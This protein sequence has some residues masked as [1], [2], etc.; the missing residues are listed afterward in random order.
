MSII[1]AK[2][3]KTQW[4]LREIMTQDY[5]SLKNS[6]KIWEKY[7]ISHTTVLKRSKS[8][9]LENR[10]SAPHKPARKHDFRKLVLLHFLYKKENNTLDEIEDIL[11]EQW[12]KMPRSTIWYYLITWW[13]VK[14]RKEKC[15][16]IN[17][18]FKKYE[19]W[20]IHVDITYWPKIDW[21]KYYI[22]VAIDR[23]TRCMYYEVHDNKRAD[24]AGKFLEKT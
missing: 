3:A 20:F 10:S 6:Q 23:A 2:K 1:Y 8:D 18:K 14:E 24:T 15:K 9:N 17:Q 11:E 4:H 5:K 22:H 7:K 19:P 12:K 13:L 21:V 16:R